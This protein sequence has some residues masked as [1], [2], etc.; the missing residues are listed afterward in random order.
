MG[1]MLKLK[2]S[3]RDENLIDDITYFIRDIFSNKYKKTGKQ[4]VFLWGFLILYILS[5]LDFI[6]DLFLGLGQ[7]DD[8]VAMIYFYFTF[9]GD[10]SRYKE[11]KEQEKIEQHK[12]I[13]IDTEEIEE[14]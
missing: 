1:E 12:I 10:F 5:P 9:R 13:E 8:L 2:N 11:W 6:P 7:V 3:K 14:D 4:N